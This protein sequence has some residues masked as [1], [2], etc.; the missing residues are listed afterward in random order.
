MM[1]E[2]PQYA[3]P[4]C[5][6][7]PLSR[8]ISSTFFLAQNYH[9]GPTLEDHKQSEHTKKV[10]DLERAVRMRKKHFGRDA[11][12]DPVDR[13]DP[14]H[15]IRG[16]TLGGREMEVDKN[17]ITKALAKDPAAVAAAKAALKKAK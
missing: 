7:E 11:V 5:G 10:K 15:V 9:V 6:H 4:D 8:Q 13:P 16:K 17:E 1:S 3:C 12:G 2:D 14:K